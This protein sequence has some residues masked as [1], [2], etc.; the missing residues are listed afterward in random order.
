M[1]LV[2]DVVFTKGP[3][4]MRWRQRS[5]LLRKAGRW[6]LSGMCEHGAER[7]TLFVYADELN[8]DGKYR[9]W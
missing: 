8:F 3:M 1:V 2:N 6:T 9:D 7:D 5:L 4:I